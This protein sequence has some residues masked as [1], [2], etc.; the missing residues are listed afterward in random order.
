MS[1]TPGERPVRRAGRKKKK[2]R[3]P[4][5]AGRSA[6]PRPVAGKGNADT[7]GVRCG[8]FRLLVRESKV[9]PV[10]RAVW[11]TVRGGSGAIG[12]RLWSAPL[13]GDQR[14][15]QRRTRGAA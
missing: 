15:Y 7:V 3:T 14:R 10:N 12:V 13:V 5:A 4:D 1:H 11:A 8:R 2:E 9:Y 6:D